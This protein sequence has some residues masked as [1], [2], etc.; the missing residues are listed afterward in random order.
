MFPAEPFQS[1]N[2]SANN[3]L[4]LNKLI[5]LRSPVEWS[6]EPR[7]TLTRPGRKLKGGNIKIRSASHGTAL[8]SESF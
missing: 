7:K 2:R 8:S 5:V 6:E 4:L 1:N 3:L